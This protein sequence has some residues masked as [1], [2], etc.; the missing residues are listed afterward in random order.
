MPEQSQAAQ[1]HTAQVPEEAVRE[2][3]V[4][5]IGENGQPGISASSS[6]AAGFGTRRLRAACW[7]TSVLSKWDPT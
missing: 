7:H 4:Y 6:S 3:D 2:G 1:S 5:V